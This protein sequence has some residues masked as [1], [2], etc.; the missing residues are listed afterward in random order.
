VRDLSYHLKQP[1]FTFDDLYGGVGWRFLVIAGASLLSGT[2]ILFVLVRWILVQIENMHQLKDEPEG[3]SP[4]GQ[5][6]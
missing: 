3:I 4:A 2:F 1:D 5:L 6:I